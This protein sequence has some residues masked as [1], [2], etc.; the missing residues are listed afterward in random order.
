[1]NTKQP[2]SQGTGANSERLQYSTFRVNGRLFGIDV[3]KVQEIVRPMEMT[4]I[5]LSQDFV[6]GLINLRG[7]VVTAIGLNELFKIHAKDQQEP[8]MNVIC[9]CDGSLI[10]FLVD[11]IGDVIEVKRDDFES[12]PPTI[13][14]HISSFLSGI[15]KVEQDLLSIIDLGSVIKELNATQNLGMERGSIS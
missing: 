9:D 13:S 6:H 5:P 15:F 1:M 10:S 8:K 14:E 4:A 3:A 11:E 2:E 12:T 7:K